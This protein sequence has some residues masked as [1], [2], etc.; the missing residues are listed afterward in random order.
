MKWIHTSSFLEVLIHSIEN[1][2][3]S[4]LISDA[5]LSEK[6][7][8]SPWVIWKIKSKKNKPSY[9][10]LRK[11]KEWGILIPKIPEHKS[12]IE[13]NT[14]KTLIDDKLN[15]NIKNNQQPP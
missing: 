10:T 15:W 6:L 3:N 2:Q 1:F 4:H 13:W 12:L 7:W 14:R 9:T 5:E 11:L 8:L